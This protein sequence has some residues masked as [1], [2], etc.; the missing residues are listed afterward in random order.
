VYKTTKIITVIHPTQC[1]GFHPKQINTGIEI[2]KNCEQ[3]NDQKNEL[4]NLTITHRKI[5]KLTMLRRLHRSCSSGCYRQTFF[6]VAFAGLA[7]EIVH[8]THLSQFSPCSQLLPPWPFAIFGKLRNNRIES[9]RYTKICDFDFFPLS[10]FFAPATR[11]R[12]A[13]R[14]GSLLYLIASASLNTAHHEI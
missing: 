6:T 9:V 1:R 2:T 3:Q 14:A 12:K 13:L 11:P 5:H 8:E 10:R 7:V 4:Q